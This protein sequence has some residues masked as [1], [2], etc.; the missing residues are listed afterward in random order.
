VSQRLTLSVVIGTK[1][2]PVALMRCLQ[3][4]CDQRRPPDEV[5][6]I[7]D[8]ALEPGPFLALLKQSGIA[9]TYFR[10][11]NDPGL[12]KS[13]NLGIRQSRGAIVLFLDDDVVLAPAYVDELLKVYEGHPEAGGAGG[14]LVGHTM[15]AARR[16]FL[17]LFLL[18]SPD[19]GAILP[20]GVGVLI[21]EV[22]SVKQVQWLS[23]CNMSFRRHVFE[24]MLF[25]E[26][27]S[28]NGWGDDRDFSYAV[29]RQWPLYAAPDATLR[30]L[31]EPAGRATAT[32]FGEMEVVFL[33]RFFRKHMPQRP[34]NI[35]SLWWAVCG[36]AL[37]NILTGRF[38]RLWG[39][40]R[41]ARLVVSQRGR[42]LEETA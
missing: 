7:D 15:S 25:D 39:N 40:L 30:H 2:R 28:G 16:W 12:T 6:L 34:K 9:A 36:I 1:D 18:D 23:G 20:N 3:S 13:R 21:R 10:K 22:S 11:A 35:A 29:G 37:R 27:F 31:E 5:V 42:T 33:H 26:K 38:G 19:D 8:G 24:R 41:G 32:R 17:R 4:L 14:R